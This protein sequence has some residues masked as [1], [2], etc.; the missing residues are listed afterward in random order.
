VF[1]VRSGK[2]YKWH[3]RSSMC[4]TVL[5]LPALLAEVTEINITER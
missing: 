2:T 3:V 5:G 1:F 4:V